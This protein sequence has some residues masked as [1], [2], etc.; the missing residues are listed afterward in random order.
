[1][2]EIARRMLL[3]MQEENLSYGELSTI[4]GIPKSALFRYATGETGKVPIDRL[5]AIANALNVDAAY[6]MGWTDRPRATV[7]NETGTSEYRTRRIL[8]IF[9]D[10]VE[11]AGFSQECDSDANVVIYNTGTILDVDNDAR[12]E[13]M[14]ETLSYFSFLVERKG[15]RR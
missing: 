10:I 11:L 12:I 1:M 6:L 4:T 13:L 3:A 8:Y 15:R 9:N 14:E 5:Q 7:L 2:N